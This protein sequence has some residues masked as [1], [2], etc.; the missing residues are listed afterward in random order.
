MLVDR[1]RVF[2]LS[3][4]FLLAG[5]GGGGGNPGTTTPPS[6]PPAATTGAL[7]V[8]IN[9]LPAGTNGAVRVTGPNNFSQD[10]SGTQTLNTLAP[11]SYNVTA[12]NVTVG[13]ATTYTPSPPTQG[14]VVTAGAT[15]TATVSY[16]APALTLALSDIGPTFTNPTYLTAPPGDERLFVVE[17]RGVIRVVRNGATLAQPWLDISSNVFTGGEGG[18]LSMAFDPNF[19]SNGFFYVYYSD[20]AQNIVVE[21]YGSSPVPNVADPTSALTIL[22][23]PHP[24]FQNHFGGLVAFGPDG[25]LYA[26]TGDGGGAGDPFGNAQNLNSLLGKLLRVDVRSATAGQPYTIPANNPYVNQTGRRP[27]I[28]AYGLR[29][30]WRFA[31]DG[32]QLYTADVGQD[33]REEVNIAT[34][35]QGGL[36]YGWDMMEGTVC[37]GAATCDRTGLT[38]PV[39]EYAHG[40]NNVNGCSI[41][42]GYV[43]RGSAM[44][45]LAGRYFYSD[46][47]RGFVKSFFATGAGITEQRDW[48]LSDAG[49]V[50]SFGR[51]GAGEL[52]VISASGHIFRLVRGA[53]AQPG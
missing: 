20:P 13:G 35:S 16:A 11:G 48:N 49:R 31:F 41:N 22:R 2:L 27:E 53:S 39:F 9:S 44:P 37:F 38:L 3:L 21:R 6:A 50:V 8:V 40:A 47:C 15:A 23:I 45:E 7:Q 25:M 18:L 19:A 32:E 33:A 42:G 46:F 12:S 24:Q 51:D 14:V 29:N 43:Y 4:L 1:A 17:R 10:V 52:Y 34:L 26:G 28:W 5:C 36:N 30:P